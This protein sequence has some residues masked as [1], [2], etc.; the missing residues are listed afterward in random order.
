MLHTL[1]CPAAHLC[2]SRFGVKGFSRKL[3][4]TP[5]RPLTLTFPPDGPAMGWAAPNCSA[6]NGMNG[7]DRLRRGL[8]DSW[9]MV[10]RETIHPAIICHAAIYGAWCIVGRKNGAIKYVYA[11]EGEWGSPGSRHRQPYALPPLGYDKSIGPMV[12]TPVRWI[13]W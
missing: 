3:F 7:D 10:G 13:L 8:V 11:R 12:G 5:H 4:T 6:G 2:F 1:H 9:C